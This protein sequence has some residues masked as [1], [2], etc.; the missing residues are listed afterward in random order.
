MGK[1]EKAQVESE[2]MDEG[3][4]WIRVRYHRFGLMAIMTWS[5]TLIRLFWLCKRKG[6]T[7]IHTWCTPA[8]SM[9]YIL[10]RLTGV[11]LVLDSFEP[12]ADAMIESKTWSS[13][14]M[15]NRI[16]TRL[17][18]WQANHAKVAIGV[19]YKMEQYAQEKYGAS[20]EHYYSKPACVNLSHFSGGATKDEE[21][22]RSLGLQDKLVCVYAGKLGGIYLVQ[23]VFDFFEKAIEFWGDRFQVLFL[24]SHSRDEIESLAAQSNV[25]PQRITST[26]VPHKDVPKYMALADF[27]FTPIKPIPSKQYSTPIKD[28]EYWALGL[29]VVITRDISDDS[30]I[31]ENN[32]IGAVIQSLDDA[33]YLR[34]IGLINDLLETESRA[35][36]HD[37]IRKI[38]TEH[39]S[40][41]IAERI[42]QEIYG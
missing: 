21:L 16:L 30:E 9:G 17:E 14:S 29:P 12:H 37:R 38:A 5:W 26:F 34:C 20:F 25:D 23:E 40:F 35:E 15:A 22:L 7:R 28:G 3:I 41:D 6:I 32:R 8:G 18:K 33:E 4:D 11:P 10:S 39:R 1:T 42:Y 31:I 36:L 2:L 19:N 24:T 13:S 27:A